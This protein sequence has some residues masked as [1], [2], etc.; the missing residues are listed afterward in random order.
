M[1]PALLLALT[2]QSTPAPP[3]IPPQ[4]AL[5]E[6]IAAR[7]AEL[8]ALLFTGPCDTA[9]FRSLVTDDVEFYHDK[10]GAT[11]GADAFVADFARFCA[12]R[13]DPAAWRS[14]RV[15][16]RE[17]L[18][19]DPVPGVGA[20]EAGEHLFYERHGVNG[21]EHLVGRARFAQ[22]WVLGADRAWRLSR[23]FSFAHSPASEPPVTAQ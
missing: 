4:P 19:V 15:L 12:G 17:S 18:R 21:A 8:F 1:P 13:Q 2:L 16:V 10:D 14:R 20:I 7:D 9:H 3:A 23:V 11:R 6:A 5:T 22:L